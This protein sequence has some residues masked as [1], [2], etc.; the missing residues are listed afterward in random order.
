MIQDC[1][2]A[3]EA[4]GSIGEWMCAHATL[5]EGMADGGRPVL[6]QGRGVIAETCCRERLGHTNRTG[7]H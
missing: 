2:T 5:A 4:W 3:G 1:G 6:I 7:V